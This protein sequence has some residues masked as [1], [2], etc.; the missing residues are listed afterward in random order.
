[1]FE[2]YIKIYQ[3]GYFAF[4]AKELGSN[5]FVGAGGGEFTLQGNKYQET[6]DF[7]TL[8]PDEVGTTT[9]YNLDLITI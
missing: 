1:M 6:L 7:F 3:D 2:Q 5:K 4:G 8:I 9:V